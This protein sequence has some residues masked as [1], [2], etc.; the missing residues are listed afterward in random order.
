MEFVMEIFLFLKTSTADW[1]SLFQFWSSA[2]NRISISITSGDE[3]KGALL[4]ALKAE[5][6]R[7]KN[8]LTTEANGNFHLI[9]IQTQLF[10]I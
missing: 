8:R 10:A 4:L 6:S 1:N 3:A 9:V 7:H 2:D 5:T